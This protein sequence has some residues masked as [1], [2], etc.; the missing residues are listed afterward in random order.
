MGIDLRNRTFTRDAESCKFSDDVSFFYGPEYIRN[1]TIDFKHNPPKGLIWFHRDLRV[2]DHAGI[3]VVQEAG[4]CWIALALSPRTPLSPAGCF[5]RECLD[6]LEASLKLLEIPLLRLES[7]EVESFIRNVF[8]ANPDL[9]LLTSRRFNSRDQKLL[10]SCTSVLPKKQITLYDHG[11]LYLESDLPFSLDGLP[12]TFSPFQ[13]K[14]RAAKTQIA[15]PISGFSLP[16]VSANG[17]APVELQDRSFRFRG[18]QRNA[19]LR[20]RDYFWES[21]AVMHYHETRNGLLARD[22][23]SKLSPYLAQGCISA[24]QVHAEILR[25]QDQIGPSKGAEALLYELEWRDYFKFLALRSGDRLFRAQGLRNEER[26]SCPDQKQFERWC[27]GET[28]N[29]FIDA[30][31]RELKVSGWMSNRGRQNV[32]SFLAR[33]MKLPWLWGASWFEENLSDFD[34]ET[35]QGNWMYLAGVG[36]DPRDRIFNP[37]L[38]AENY[39]GD[40]AYRKRWS[41]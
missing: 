10:D 33:I 34:V 3:K 22:D 17:I 15:P 26:E 8:H 38:Q 39:D 41:S 14:I 21:R 18:G 40:G 30:N 36:T 24:R 6:D 35:N 5:E 20:L 28:G 7:T 25:L 16:E 1:V 37:D 13:R 29:D 31:M 2:N 9:A 32:A 27:A 4:G 19:I 23:S 11:T 12:A